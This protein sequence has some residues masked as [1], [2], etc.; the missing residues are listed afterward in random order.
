MYLFTRS[1]PVVLSLSV[2]AACITAPTAPEAIGPAETAA[3]KPVDD[4]ESAVVSVGNLAFALTMNAP[5]A[6]HTATLLPDGRILIAGGFR[7]EGRSEIPV[8]SAELYDPE[9]NAFYPT[10]EMKEARS[11]HTAT[12]LPS[13]QVIIIG[14]WG[15]Q[16][17]L[18]TA[19]LYDPQSGAFSHAA[20][21]AAPR[22]SMTATLL[23]DGRLLIAGGDSARNKLQ[24]STELYDPVT[25]T[26]IEGGKLNQGRFAHTAT[27]LKNGRVLLI[28]GRSSNNTILTSAELYDPATGKF[29]YTGN[30]ETVRYKHAAVLLQEGNVLVVGGSDHRDWRGQYVS[31]ELYHVGKGVFTRTADLNRER[32][33]LADAVAL[34][35]NG[36]VLVAGGNRQIEIFDPRHQRFLLGESLDNDAYYSVATPLLDGSVLITGGYDATIHPST[37]AWIYRL[38]ANR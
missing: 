2:L 16:G 3:L 20:S 19:E 35:E 28:G 12:L 29:T 8:A 33:K 25:N 4:M 31:A 26:F 6:A 18:A 7:S 23:E 34:L 17:R 11:G 27:L 15:V 13:G 38:E 30:L 32:F 9:R 14:G 24:V 1:L 22:A 5:R 36:N 21:M 10:G 37:K